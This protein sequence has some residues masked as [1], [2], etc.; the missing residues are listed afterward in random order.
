MS[1]QRAPKHQII[2]LGAVLVVMIGTYEPYVD[3]VAKD[4][5]TNPDDIISLRATRAWLFSTYTRRD[6]SALVQ[7]EC[8][9][10][11]KTRLLAN[12]RAVVSAT[13]LDPKY[14]KSLLELATTVDV[15][16]V[17]MITDAHNHLS[18]GDDEQYRSRQIAIFDDQ[19]T[20]MRN[21]DYSSRVMVIDRQ[22]TFEVIEPVHPYTTNISM[23]GFTT[24]RVIGDVHGN[25]EGL[26]SIIDS[27]P[28]HTLF[29][30]LGDI[31]DYGLKSWPVVDKIYE[32]LSTGR[33]LMVQGN[34]DEK[35]GRFLAATK[36]G[37]PFTGKVGHGM[38][39]STH[40]LTRMSPKVLARTIYRYETIMS[41]SRNWMTIVSWLF[42]HGAA[43]PRMFEEPTFHAG[44]KS[45]LRVL[46]LYGESDSNVVDEMGRP[47]RTYVWIAELPEN[48]SVMV[49]HDVRSFSEPL[50]VPKVNGGQVVFLDTGSSKADTDGNVG[51]LSYADFVLPI[52]DY[53]EMVLHTT[54][55]GS[56]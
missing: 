37:T 26:R 45:K 2:P 4:T 19:H 28:D 13:N 11:A 49:G 54:P 52:D 35:M 47:T 24:M 41:L 10:R 38:E 40:Q 27:A 43:H 30:F 23:D 18:H 53:H 34:H 3:M 36:A 46:S 48:V 55:F 9:H 22:D 51:K 14:R 6:Q 56:V 42:T 32:L 17:Y 1:R 31:V 29:V 33:A 50:V 8:V 7:A 12:K 16:V 15:P 39:T 20:N 25:L 21:G 44:K 5:F